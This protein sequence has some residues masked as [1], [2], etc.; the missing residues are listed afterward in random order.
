MQKEACH[1]A[2]KLNCKIPDQCFIHLQLQEQ[3]DLSGEEEKE[4]K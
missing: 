2:T 4:E 1:D 3:M